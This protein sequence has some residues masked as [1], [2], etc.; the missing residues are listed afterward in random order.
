MATPENT[1]TASIG[2]GQLTIG[3]FTHGYEGMDIQEQGGGANVS[4]GSFCSIGRNLKMLLEES[5]A[6]D[7]LSAFPF[8]EVFTEELGGAEVHVPHQ[9]SGDIAIGH[10]VW[11]GANVTLLGGVCIGHGAVISPNA[12]VA[13]DVGCYEIWAGNPAQLVRKRFDDTVCAKLLELEWWSLP[14]EMIQEMAP[15]LSTQPSAE[16]IDG[17]QSIVNDLVTVS[18]ESAA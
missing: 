5:P 14:V 6:L 3:R 16:L 12:T 17:L 18:N 11:I 13:G 8:G 7:Q 1:K 10:D 2:N 15:L 4:I 9:G